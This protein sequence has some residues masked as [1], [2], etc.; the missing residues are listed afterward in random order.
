MNISLHSSNQ[1][2]FIMDSGYI[3]CEA[4]T[5]YYKYRVIDLS[6]N[7]YLSPSL[8]SHPGMWVLSWQA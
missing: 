5:K 7:Y 8:F 3:I 1:F 6:D 2:V 4:E